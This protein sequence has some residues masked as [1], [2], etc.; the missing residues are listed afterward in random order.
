MLKEDFNIAPKK[1]LKAIITRDIITLEPVIRV[2]FLNPA[3]ERNFYLRP[4]SLSV[5]AQRFSNKELGEIYSDCLLQIH[6]MPDDDIPPTFKEIMDELEMII[7]RRKVKFCV[8][9]N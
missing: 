2:S 9:I 5:W 1:R 4:K 3:R 8:R 6:S 7:K